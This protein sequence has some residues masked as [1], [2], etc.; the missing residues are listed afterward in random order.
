MSE[1][2][3][4]RS[5]GEICP[6]CGQETLRF[7][8]KVCPQCARAIPDE[9]A[10]KLTK[11]GMPSTVDG[12]MVRAA[13]FEHEIRLD[14]IAEQ[15]LIYYQPARQA[16]RRLFRGLENDLKQWTH[17]KGL[18]FATKEGIEPSPPTSSSRS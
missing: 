10:V 1:E 13:L 18:S 11:I 6:A 3:W 4:E 5:R 12:N 7:I 9:L 16:E 17:D 14:F 8:G 15:G 2:S